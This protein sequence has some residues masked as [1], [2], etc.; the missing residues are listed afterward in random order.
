MK[1]I[2]HRGNLYAPDKEMENEPNYILDAIKKDVE[3]EVDVWTYEENFYLGH[4]Y[5]KYEVDLMFL[6]NPKLWIHAKDIKT[7]NNLIDKVAHIFFHQADDVT[8]TSSRYLWTYVGKP[9]YE[10]SI[11]V[12]PTKA[13]YSIEELSKCSGVCSDN[14]IKYKE[15]LE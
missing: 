3:V 5:P 11:A 15:L 8:L 13:G 1:F 7:L 9:L 2:S 10:K 14:I 12:L 4:E 6:L